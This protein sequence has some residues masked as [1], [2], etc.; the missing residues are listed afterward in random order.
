M[1]E[2]VGRFRINVDSVMR[3]GLNRVATLI[4]AFELVTGIAVD[5]GYRGATTGAELCWGHT[6]L[7]RFV[8]HYVNS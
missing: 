3:G 2:S 1:I 7:V 4:T 5:Q 8:E 6:L